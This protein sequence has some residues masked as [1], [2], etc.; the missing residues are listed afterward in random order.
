[1]K[2]YNFY[3]QRLVGGNVPLLRHRLYGH[4]VS[5]RYKGENQSRKL[6]RLLLVLNRIN[7]G[8]KGHYGA[9]NNT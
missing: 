1:M 4:I 6:P 2:H 3:L 8:G 7:L 5:F 9:W